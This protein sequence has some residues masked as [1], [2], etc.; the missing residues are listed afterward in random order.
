MTED[1]TDV[2]C[3]WTLEEL[4]TCEVNKLQSESFSS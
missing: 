3:E 4:H 2:I 1:G